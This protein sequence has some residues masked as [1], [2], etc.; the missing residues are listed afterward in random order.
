MWGLAQAVH[1]MHEGRAPAL[2]CQAVHGEQPPTLT[3][4]APRCA[5]AIQSICYQQAGRAAVCAQEGMQSLLALLVSPNAKVG[6]QLG[7]GR[8]TWWLLGAGAGGRHAASGT[9]R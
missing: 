5:G 4:H 6:A 2:S 3:P 1:Q 7:A 8:C 9:L